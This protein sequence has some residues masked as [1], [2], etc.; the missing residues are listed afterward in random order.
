MTFSVLV[1]SPAA[2]EDLRATH[3]YGIRYWGKPRSDDYL[4]ALK[5]TL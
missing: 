5:E 1:I 2:R 3:Q 4:T